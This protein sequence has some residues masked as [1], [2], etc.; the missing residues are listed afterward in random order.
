M[1]G[2]EL[3]THRASCALRTLLCTRPRASPT[4]PFRASCF[5]SIA[6]CTPRR[7]SIPPLEILFVL[8]GRQARQNQIH[9]FLLSRWCNLDH[10]SRWCNFSRRYATQGAVAEGKSKADVLTVVKLWLNTRTLGSLFL[11][12]DATRE[13]LLTLSLDVMA[14]CCSTVVWYTSPPPSELGRL[15][16]S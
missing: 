10:F 2:I 14:R 8:N 11:Q 9:G 12:P 13:G 4:F 3:H 15:P 5:P 16:W 6:P 1:W 7:C